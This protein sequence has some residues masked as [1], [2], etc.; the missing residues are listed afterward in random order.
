ME[1]LVLPN[2]LELMRI[3]NIFLVKFQ[4]KK[5]NFIVKI[6]IERKLRNNY[7]EINSY[8]LLPKHII[9]NKKFKMWRVGK[10]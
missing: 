10:I 7:L 6:N 4:R 9:L 8:F 5:L 2:I 3:Q 1:G